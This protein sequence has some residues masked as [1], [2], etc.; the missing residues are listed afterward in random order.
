[1]DNSIDDNIDCFNCDNILEKNEVGLCTSCEL[2]RALC[3][4]HYDIENDLIYDY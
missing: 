4:D 3:H 1:M 2:E